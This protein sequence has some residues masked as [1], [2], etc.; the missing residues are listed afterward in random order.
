MRWAD[1]PGPVTS[2]YRM[3]L[4]AL[5][6]L[7]AF[8][9]HRPRQALPPRW[10]LLPVLAGLFS[11][12]DHAVWSTA[13]QRTT[14]ANATLLNNLAPIWV[15][16]FAWLVWRQ[17]LDGRFWLG[18]ALACGGALGVLGS[19][20]SLPTL[21]GDVL[22]LLSSLFYAGYYLV[23][24]RARRV[25]DT[26]TCVW[27]VTCAS[28]LA[29]LAANLLWGHALSGYSAPTWI[30]F[31]GVALISQV[32]GYF[33]IGYALGHLPAAVVAP[34]MIAQPVLTALLAIPLAGE[35]LGFW[36]VVGGVGVLA[37]IFLVVRS[38][39]GSST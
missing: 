17:R 8:G 14:I 22:G 32:M 33:S 20:W 7:P 28:A 16:L 5:I 36:Q 18:L 13:I 6:L 21:G 24:Q 12:A 29:L 10:Y 2:F 11:A 35:N 30:S 34:T 3:A 15:A 1:A 25:L 27:L 39:R 4:G 19:R 38:E 31:V 9:L 26:L 23:A 37:G